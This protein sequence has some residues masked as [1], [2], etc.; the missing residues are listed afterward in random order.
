MVKHGT[1]AIKIAEIS[2]LNLDDLFG[3]NEEAA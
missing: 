1:R 3:M 2:L